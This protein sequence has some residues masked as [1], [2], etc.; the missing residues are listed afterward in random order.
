[1]LIS[2]YP[3]GF[4]LPRMQGVSGI[5]G[6]LNFQSED[7]SLQVETGKHSIHELLSRFAD[8]GLIVNPLLESGM[9][10]GSFRQGSLMQVGPIFVCHQLKLWH[11]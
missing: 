2:G 11:F 4:S 1:M 5:M 3:T 9:I 8:M 10:Q 6:I 7:L